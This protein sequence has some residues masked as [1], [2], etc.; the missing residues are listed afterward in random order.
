MI[1]IFRK[2]VKFPYPKN[3]IRIPT[4]KEGEERNVHGCNEEPSFNIPY[5]THL[6]VGYIL[7]TLNIKSQE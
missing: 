5:P 7:K 4:Q 1:G 2:D 3:A 6:K